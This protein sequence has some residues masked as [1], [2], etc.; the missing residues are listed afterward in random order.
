M[1]KA[2]KK[3]FFGGVVTG[4]ILAP[5]IMFSAGWIVTSGASSAAV[6]ASAQEA[7]VDS[8]APICVMQFSEADGR[9]DQ[10]A[11]LKSLSH[12]D[13]PDFVVQSGWATMPGAESSNRRVATEC[14]KRLAA[15]EN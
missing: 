5:V 4:A 3:L 8:L 15:L 6:Q 11:K 12:W 9:A 10:L 7:V 13:R 14:A 2:S 1:A